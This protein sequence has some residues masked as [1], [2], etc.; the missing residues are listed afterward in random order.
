MQESGLNSVLLRVD[1][2][3]GH[4]GGKPTSKVI[5]EITDEFSF[6]FSELKVE[7]R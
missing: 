4:G 1:V 2:S 6:L 5:E 3:T 7:Y